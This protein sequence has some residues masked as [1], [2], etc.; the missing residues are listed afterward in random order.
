MNT[1]MDPL[2]KCRGSVMGG[3]VEGLLKESEE[4]VPE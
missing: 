3:E 2:G 4:A 1:R